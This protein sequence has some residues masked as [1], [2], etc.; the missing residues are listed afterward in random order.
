[1]RVF[2]GG[3]EVICVITGDLFVLMILSLYFS[4]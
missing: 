3:G 4:F 1:M 2:G